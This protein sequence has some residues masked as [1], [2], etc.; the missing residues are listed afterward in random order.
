MAKRIASIFSIGSNVSDQSQHSNSSR[1]PSSIHP[2]RPPKEQNSAGAVADPTPELQPTDDLHNL[3]THQSAGLTPRLDDEH[4]MLQSP[5]LL[6][7][8]PI[9]ETSP[10]GSRRA[11]I[12]SRPHSRLGSGDPNN[13]PSIHKPLP[14]GSESPSGN[15]PVS[16]GSYGGS[17]AGSRPDSR[18]PSRPASPIKSRSQTPTGEQR[19]GKR[20]GWLPG[21]TKG[22]MPEEEHSVFPSH[23]WVVTPHEKLPY[24]TVP[25]SH[26]KKVCLPPAFIM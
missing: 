10:N 7:P 23:A 14:I 20:R 12:S 16:G 4:L 21:K 18:S 17:N 9:D 24:D 22:E 25:L 1:V 13:Q 2:A 6:S 11:S 8:I 15:R 19:L 26:F 5:Q 3:H